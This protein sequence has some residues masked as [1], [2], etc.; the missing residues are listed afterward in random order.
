MAESLL[1]MT[2]IQKAFA[3]VPALRDASL[4][5]GPGEVHALVG[6]NGAGKSTL[7]KILTGVYSRDAGEV[8]FGGQ[9]WTYAPRARR[10][11]RASPPST[12]S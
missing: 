9:W 12:R 1:Q 3:G 2:G 5:I 6:Q 8:R 11:R 10:K 4:R 7:I